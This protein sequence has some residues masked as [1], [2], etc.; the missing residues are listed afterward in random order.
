MG[1]LEGKT[2]L[3][4]GGNSGVGIECRGVSRIDAAATL[5]ERNCL[6]TAASRKSKPEAETAK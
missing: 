2:A 1:K 4:T 3:I 5:P 6:R